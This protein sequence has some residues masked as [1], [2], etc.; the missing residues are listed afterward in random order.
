MQLLLH[1]TGTYNI[2]IICVKQV[3]V[4]VYTIRVQSVG[5][6]RNRGEIL[7]L[8]RLARVPNSSSLTRELMSGRYA[9]RTAH[10]GASD[11]LKSY[12]V[13][14]NEEGKLQ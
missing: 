5:R 2:K 1:I 4:K 9:V 13:K 14:E 6:G 12:L 10:M 3:C 11:A 8:A 7:L